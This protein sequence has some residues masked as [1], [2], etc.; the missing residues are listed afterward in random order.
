M[1]CVG[2]VIALDDKTKNLDQKIEKIEQY[3]NKTSGEEKIKENL[4]PDK[5][6][7]ALKNNK[8]LI[9]IFSLKYLHFLLYCKN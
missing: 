8:K 4:E 5:L 3:I 7:S 9:L 2:A 1:E 6:E